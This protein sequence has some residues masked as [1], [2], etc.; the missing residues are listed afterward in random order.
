MF[1]TNK[2]QNGLQEGGWLG[3]E[4]KPWIIYLRFSLYQVKL[5]SSENPKSCIWSPNW[6]LEK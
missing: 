1:Y 4:T 6:Q 3:N 2:G 5:L